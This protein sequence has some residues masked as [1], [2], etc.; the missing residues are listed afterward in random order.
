MLGVSACMYMY[1]SKISILGHPYILEQ[2]I[3]NPRHA[4]AASV[5]VVVLY[6]CVCLCYSNSGSACNIASYQRYIPVRTA[7]PAVLA[8]YN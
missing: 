7:V 5:T 6:V 2:G 3:I 4:C 8:K 1:I